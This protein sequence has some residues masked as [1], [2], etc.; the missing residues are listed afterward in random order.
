MRCLG[1]IIYALLTAVAAQ[2]HAAVSEVIFVIGM[3]DAIP[4]LHRQ[5]AAR[6]G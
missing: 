6:G 3:R 5:L 1:L 2:C 4:H